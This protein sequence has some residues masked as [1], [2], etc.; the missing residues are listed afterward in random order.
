[1]WIWNEDQRCVLQVVRSVSDVSP[2]SVGT[3]GGATITITG[4]GFNEDSTVTV[5]DSECTDVMFVSRAELTCTV[6]A[7]SAGTGA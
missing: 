6:P 3:T 2:A 5:D 1:M 7:L 4:V